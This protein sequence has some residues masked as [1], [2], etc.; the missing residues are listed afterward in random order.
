M[1]ENVVFPYLI[2]GIISGFLGVVIILGVIKKWNLI[3]D[4]PEELWMY[5]SHSAIKKFFGKEALIPINYILGIGFLLL[6]VHAFY[7]IALSLF[8]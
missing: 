4:P 7:K 2:E 3:V 6:G 1:E 8:F 5:Y